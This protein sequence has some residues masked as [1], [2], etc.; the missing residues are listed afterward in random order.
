MGSVG[1][2][3]RQIQVVHDSDDRVIDRHEP[4]VERHR[5]FA[6]AL[7]IHQFAFAGHAGGIAGHDD[8]ALGLAGLVQRL[9]QQQR[10]A[11]EA[12]V[13]HGSDHAADDASQQHQVVSPSSSIS[14]PVPKWL[15]V[16]TR[17][18]MASCGEEMI[19]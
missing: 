11:R 9:H 6:A 12:L 16:C 2:L 8:L 13:D 1:F 15:G 18:L 17:V 4:R 3:L 7:V 10:H 5:G 19:L 14:E